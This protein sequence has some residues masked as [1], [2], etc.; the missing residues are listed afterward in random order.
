MSSERRVEILKMITVDPQTGEEGAIGYGMLCSSQYDTGIV[1]VGD[2]L[3]EVARLADGDLSNEEKLWD[4]VGMFHP[5]IGTY[6]GWP[7]DVPDFL[8]DA[9]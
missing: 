7:V 6:S 5:S 8:T 3:E 4:W 9:E 2:T 1:R